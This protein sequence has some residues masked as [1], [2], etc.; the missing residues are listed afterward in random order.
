MSGVYV[1]RNYIEF[2][3]R[4]GQPEFDNSAIYINGDNFHVT[5]NTFVSTA[6]DEARTAIE[7]HSGSGARSAATPSIT[8]QSG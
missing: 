6:A 1:H 5:D 3:K 7:I 4:P 8:S 2:H